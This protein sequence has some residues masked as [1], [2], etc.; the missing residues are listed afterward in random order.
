LLKER[1][2]CIL[3]RYRNIGPI[4]PDGP[5]VVQSTAIDRNSASNTRAQGARPPSVR[6]DLVL[7]R[8]VP[9]V[10][11]VSGAKSCL[12]MSCALSELTK[13][14]FEASY[15]RAVIGS[16]PLSCTLL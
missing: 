16:T 7:R 5:N 12:R 9:K 3:S 10:P 13:R 1:P 15:S 11:Q 4:W 2:V 6:L 8:F 14:A